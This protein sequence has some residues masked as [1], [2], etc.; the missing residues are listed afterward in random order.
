[1]AD[2]FQE[3]CV[4]GFH[5]VRG[6][7][8]DCFPLADGGFIHDAESYQDGIEFFRPKDAQLHGGHALG[9]S[10]QTDEDAFQHDLQL[11]VIVL[12]CDARRQ[13]ENKSTERIA[14]RAISRSVITP[15]TSPMVGSTP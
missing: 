10:V 5:V 8:R 3:L 6:A 2:I 13:S 12:P 9:R 15:R 11:Q 7:Q 1:M 14:E 4:A